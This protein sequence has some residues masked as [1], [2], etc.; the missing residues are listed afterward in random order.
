MDNIEAFY[1]YEDEGKQFRFRRPTVAE[2]DLMTT[3]VKTAALSSAL[4]LTSALIVASQKTEWDAF[5][6]EFPG[7]SSTVVGD[8]MKRLKF[9][10]PD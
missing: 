10:A 1:T 5:V 6:S 7:A 8:I 9:R 2:L 3:R 4:N